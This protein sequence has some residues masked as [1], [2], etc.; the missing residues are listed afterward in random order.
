MN[1]AKTAAA[2][3]ASNRRGLLRG[4]GLSVGAAGLTALAAKSAV[5]DTTA[6][7][8]PA[9]GAALQALTK[10]LAAIPRRRDFKTVPMILT[11][12]DLWDSEALN[13]VIHYKGSRKQVWDNTD[14]NGPWL[15]LMR[16]AVNAQVWSWK[17]PDFLAVSATHGSA[18]LALYDQTIWDKYGLAGFTGGKL[19]SN[20]LII[21][22]ATT[23]PIADFQNPT[24]SFSPVGGDTIPILQSR[25]VVF[26]GCHNAI[27]EFSGA[28]LKKGTNPDNLSH[29]A[30]AAEL[31]NHLIPGVVLSPGVVGTIPELQA[32]GFAYN[33]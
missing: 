22:P 19:A 32:T 28:L 14:I 25:G 5:A 13:A 8:E 21:P 6:S 2:T 33:S 23:T 15:N 1:E 20:S 10:K 9:S 12:E 3:A 27:W 11:T 17:H 4:I 31:T 26:I 16:N 24:G 29:P 7:L 30:L 18:H